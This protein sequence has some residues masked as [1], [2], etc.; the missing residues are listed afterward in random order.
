MKNMHCFG[1]WR[2]RTPLVLSVLVSIHGTSSAIA[3][4]ITPPAPEP[5]DRAITITLAG[6]TGYAP[7]NARV[8]PKGVTRHGQFQ[9]WADT[10]AA[11]ARHIDGDINFVNIETI[12]TDKNNLRRDTKGQR[13]PFNFRTHPNGARHLVERGF[14]VFSLANNHSMDYGLAGLKE[15]LR[16]VEALKAHG[17]KA[18]AGLGMNRDEASQPH[19]LPVKGSSIGYAAI[20]IVTNNLARHRAGDN[21]PGQIAYRFD[22][23][24][25]LSVDRLKKTDSEYKMLSIHYGLEGRVRT[26]AMQIRD[27]RNRAALEH[28]IDLIVGH[29]AHVPRGVEIAGTSVIFYGLGNFLHHGTAN[30]TSKGICKDFGIFAKV[31]LANTASGDLRAQALEVIPV[32][33]THRKPKPMATA[34]GRARIHAL[35]YLGSRLGSKD[36]RAKGVRFT[37]QGDG[38]GLYCFS[39]AGKR[40]DKIGALCRGLKPAPAIPGILRGRIARSCAR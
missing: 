26:D 11:I 14:N 13:G 20:G 23:D 2:C 1:T 40:T 19:V 18:H 9:T 10:T 4:P 6:D 7:N 16:H 31:H 38:S 27:W 21:K 25:K 36:G 35:N 29:H 24:F 32:T 39:G 28:G 3:Q 30:M 17:L 5:V 12:V 37:P 34:A 8:Q 15:T 33:N 22:E